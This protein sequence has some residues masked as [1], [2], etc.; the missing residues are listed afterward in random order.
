MQPTSAT[1]NNNS[2][3]TQT[4]GKA[5]T[6]SPIVL[7][8]NAPTSKFRE[9]RKNR[10]QLLSLRTR[11][12]AAIDAPKPYPMLDFAPDHINQRA[13]IRSTR[14]DSSPFAKRATNQ[15]L[16]KQSRNRES[17][18]Q[19]LRRRE[20]ELNEEDELP[21]LRPPDRRAVERVFLPSSFRSS[22]R[23]GVRGCLPRGG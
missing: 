18:Q 21:E 7:L 19:V 22:R 2:S 20:R 17:P 14:T 23:V 9:K 3:T 15:S 1:Y 5:S 13:I 11:S 16:A 8:Q 12:S 4:H 10:T 6:F